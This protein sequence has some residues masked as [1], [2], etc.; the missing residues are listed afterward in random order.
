MMALLHHRADVIDK[1]IALLKCQQRD[2]TMLQ[3]RLGIDVSAAN[4]SLNSVETSGVSTV[5]QVDPVQ[6]T[7]S[8]T[9]QSD[10]FFANPLAANVIDDRVFEFQEFSDQ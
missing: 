1:Q 4:E 10:V 6:Q 8:F 7:G 9:S 5:V 2:L 3:Q